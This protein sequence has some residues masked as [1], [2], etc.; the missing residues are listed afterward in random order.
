MK[1]FFKMSAK[2]FTFSILDFF[3]CFSLITKI[4]FYMYFFGSPAFC[5]SLN[6]KIKK[7]KVKVLE[8]VFLKLKMAI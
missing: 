7:R 1:I 8:F 5:A 4:F 6:K 2:T 3:P